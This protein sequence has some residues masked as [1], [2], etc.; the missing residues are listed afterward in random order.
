MKKRDTKAASKSNKKVTKAAPK[1]N[2]P[3][4]VCMVGTGEYTTGYVYG[5]PANSDK[6]CGGKYFLKLNI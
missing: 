5:L 6:R 3:I 1:S 2:K 4:D